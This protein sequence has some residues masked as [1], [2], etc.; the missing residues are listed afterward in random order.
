MA[1]FAIAVVATML[2]VP[3][4]LVGLPA[5]VAGAVVAVMLLFSNRGGKGTW[6]TVMSTMGLLLTG[7]LS[8]MFAMQAVFYREFS[9]FQECR[10]N[11]LTVAASSACQKTFEDAVNARLHEWESRFLPTPSPSAS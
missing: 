4:S 9:D 8:T 10:A 3:W 7:L 2:P 11:A 1:L 6:L 5:S